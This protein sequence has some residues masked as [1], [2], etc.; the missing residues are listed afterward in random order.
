MNMPQAVIIA[1]GLIASA[2]VFATLTPANSAV[3]DTGRYTC[4]LDSSGFIAV[5]DTQLGQMWVPTRK[6]KWVKL[7]P[8]VPKSA[9]WPLS[10]KR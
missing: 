2:I 7:S 5:C 1:A 3:P 8:F 6:G 10:V 9:V 4:H